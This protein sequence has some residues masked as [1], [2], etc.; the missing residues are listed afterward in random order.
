MT[1]NFSSFNKNIHRTLSGLNDD[2]NPIEYF[3]NEENKVG[4]FMIGPDPN[5]GGSMYTDVMNDL[6][7]TF[8]NKGINVMRFSF[9]KYPI[10]INDKYIKY[11]QQSS[12]CFE[13]FLKTM[14]DVKYIIVLGYS[15]G[16]LMALQLIL[17]RIEIMSFICIAPP[18]L[19]YDFLPCIM[20]KMTQGCMIYGT[21]DL[22]V[23]SKSI[24]SYVK[25]LKANKINT[26]LINIDGADHYFKNTDTNNYREQLISN[27]LGYIEK[28]S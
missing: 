14:L 15:F 19:T 5:W 2:S 18:I 1:N 3:I 28:L 27:I 21:N 7:N 6:F 10:S 8:V 26:K 16:S 9:L 24:E 11:I 17:R 23:P 13:E 25:C 20:Q 12:I 4:I 22:L